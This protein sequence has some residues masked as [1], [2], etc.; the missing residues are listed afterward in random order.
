MQTE[1]AYLDDPFSGKNGLQESSGLHSNT[2]QSFS[3][4][5]YSANK[6]SIRKQ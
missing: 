1:S 5:D 2:D 3:I 6:E 4:R